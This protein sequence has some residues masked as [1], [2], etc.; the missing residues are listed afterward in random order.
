MSPEEVKGQRF[1]GELPER[2][3]SNQ[4]ETPVGPAGA[5]AW[6]AAQVPVLLLLAT[7][8][9][10]GCALLPAAQPVVAT[11]GLP[12]PAGAQEATVV[13]LVDGD[14]VIL[15][16]RGVGPLPA[17][18][19]RV[20]VLLVDT[21]EVHTEQECFGEEASDRAAELLP[22]GA[23]VRVEADRDPED[24]FGRALLHVWADGVNVGEA[25]VREGFASVLVVRP[26]E[27]YLEAFE[28][29]EAQAR[30]ADLGLWGVCR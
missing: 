19:T 5:A 12:V 18:P 6:Q 30:N 27:R 24:R 2:T 7:V 9:L 13:R 10:S 29:A 28:Q 3:T 1:G 23:V 15:R 4:D 22:E 16:G 8:L 11:P 17:E 25:L 20:R 26:N 14:T 21:P